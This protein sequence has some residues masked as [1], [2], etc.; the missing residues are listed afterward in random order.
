PAAYPDPHRMLENI[1]AD[2]RIATSASTPQRTTDGHFNFRRNWWQ[3]AAVFLALCGAVLWGY[4]NFYTEET[5][6]KEQLSKVSI[7]PGSDKA[8][9]ILEDGKQI[10]LSL[11]RA[12]TVLDQGEYLI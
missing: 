12:D 2:P 8:M 1:L 11:L 5:Q 10:D 9:I 3:V 4:Y 6:P 7:V